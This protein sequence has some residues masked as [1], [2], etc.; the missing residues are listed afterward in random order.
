M[1]QLRFGVIGAAGIGQIMSVAT[2]EQMA[3]GLIPIKVLALCDTNEERLLQVTAKVRA[4][5]VEPVLYHDYHKMLNAVDVVYVGLPNFLHAEAVV[6]AA[7]VGVHILCEKPLARTLAEALEMARV[8]RKAGVFIK[9]QYN[10]LATKWWQAIVDMILSGELIVDYMFFHW[11][12][13][14]G[15]PNL[16][17]WFSD[18]ELSGGGAMIDL[19][20]HK[21][22]CVFHVASLLGL[23]LLEV[24]CN[25]NQ[26]LAPGQSMAGPYG[27]GNIGS[28]PVNV[29]MD[30][31]LR[32]LF[33]NGVV[34]NVRSAWACHSTPVEEYEAVVGGPK[35][36]AKMFRSW[37]ENDGTDDSATER[38]TLQSQRN[39]APC[40]TVFNSNNDPRSRDQLMGRDMTLKPFIDGILGDEEAQAS[41]LMGLEMPLR[42]QQVMELGYQSAANGGR[43]IQVEKLVF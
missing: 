32:L 31:R 29:E 22:C 20:S 43:T 14:V 8:V 16:G 3:K 1:K 27:T 33:T 38:L 21:L 5:G 25:I 11:L 39:G 18:K 42:I 4:L 30:S 35:S 19:S 2:A 12:R 37:S 26:A 15:G 9:A 41:P 28:G 13:A 24:S 36:E 23:E 34:A 7:A 6:A 10:N 17:L 40:V